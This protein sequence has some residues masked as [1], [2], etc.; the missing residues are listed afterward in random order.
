MNPPK[1]LARLVFSLVRR[2]MLEAD[3]AHQEAGNYFFALNVSWQPL[4][5]RVT[6][7]N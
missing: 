3:G 1:S 4:Q 6:D 5:V 2:L 7:R